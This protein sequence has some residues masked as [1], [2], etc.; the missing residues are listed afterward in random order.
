MHK[1]TPWTLLRRRLEPLANELHDATPWRIDPPATVESW[2]MNLTWFELL[3]CDHACESICAEPPELPNWPS[4]TAA[5]EG[6]PEDVDFQERLARQVMHRFLFALDLTRR[7]PV[8]YRRDRTMT[9]DFAHDA[10][11][12]LIRGWRSGAALYWAR[13]FG[14][15]YRGDGS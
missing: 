3:V 12:V 4:L 13:E 1:L 2:L 11:E 8:G 5:I 14:P 6:P 15:S 10:T 9:G 7:M